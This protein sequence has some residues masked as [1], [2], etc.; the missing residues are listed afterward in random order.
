MSLSRK[1]FNQIIKNGHIVNKNASIKSITLKIN[2]TGSDIISHVDSNDS[3]RTGTFKP[4]NSSRR[5]NK[6]KA[7]HP[8]EYYQAQ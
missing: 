7:E 3:G 8:Q 6:L 5:L 1:S 4:H 2:E